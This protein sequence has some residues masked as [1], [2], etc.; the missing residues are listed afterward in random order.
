MASNSAFQSENQVIIRNIDHLP[1]GNI[2]LMDALPDASLNEL[3]KLR[4]DIHWTVYTPYIDT[5]EYL[6]SQ[7]VS[8]QDNLKVHKSA[9]LTKAQAGE[10]DAVIIYYPKAKLRFDYYLS[11]VSQLL[12]TDGEY[13][14]IGEKKGGVKGCDK[15]LNKF[16]TGASKIDSARHC[17]LF[18]AVSNNE[19]CNKTMES[20]FSETNLEINVSGETKKV[21]LASLPGVFS[22]KGLDNG[23]ELLLKNMLPV[24]GK[25]IDFGCGC[26]V[27]ATVLSLDSKNEV[28]GIDVDVLAIESSKRTFELNNVTATAIHSNG[29]AN[30]MN[31]ANQFD[32]I[33]SN[34]PFHTGLQTDYSIVDQFLKNSAVLLKNRFNMWVVA[35]SFLPYPEL[36]Q[37][38]L[39]S[40]KTIINNKRFSVYHIR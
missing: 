36:F 17:M 31:N 16:T 38:Y 24:E 13:F 3:S 9:W 27:I 14:V 19:P 1:A 29:L 30:L 25:G 4:P 39:K 40:G 32:F 8:S 26:G 15:V 18:N 6:S 23:T 22:A 7:S 21:T 33:V 34:P 20:W 35:N 37:K 2:L 11:M 5:A 10:F 28:I 12:K